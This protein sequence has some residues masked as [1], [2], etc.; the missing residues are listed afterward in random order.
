VTSTPQVSRHHRLSVSDRHVPH[1]TPLSGT[2]RARHRS[3]YVGGEHLIRRN[4]HIRPPPAHRRAYLP[5]LAHHCASFVAVERLCKAKIGPVLPCLAHSSG[6]RIRLRAE[7]S[8][9]RHRGG[10]RRVDSDL[11]AARG[12]DRARSPG[13]QRDHHREH[14]RRR[15]PSPGR[16]SPHT[17]T[18]ETSQESIEPRVESVRSVDR[19]ATHIR[20]V[21]RHTVRTT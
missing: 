10:N 2:Q 3:R 13:P 14:A 1:L 18:A 20:Q 12:R 21:M 7:L 5:R 19:C 15:S 16:D 11:P 8:D 17:P 4:L 6:N 9:H